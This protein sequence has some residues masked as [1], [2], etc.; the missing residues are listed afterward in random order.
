[1]SVPITVIVEWFRTINNNGGKGCMK[2]LQDLFGESSADIA[3]TLIW[4]RGSVI[5]SK[6]EGTVN[7]CAFAFAEVCAQDDKIEGVS[8]TSKVVFLDL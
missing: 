6:K 2:L 4:F 3:Y 8:N 7:R 5:T 1:M